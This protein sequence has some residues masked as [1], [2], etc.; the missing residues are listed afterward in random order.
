MATRL[1]TPGDPSSDTRQIVIMF[2]G[3]N[4]FTDDNIIFNPYIITNAK[5]TFLTIF[6]ILLVIFIT[7][8]F[9][10]II[11]FLFRNLFSIF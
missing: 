6:I 10:F 11:L 3:I 2:I 7:F 8:N 9:M 5:H 4:I 1:N